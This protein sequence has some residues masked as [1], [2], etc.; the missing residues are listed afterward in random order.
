MTRILIPTDG[1]DCSQKTLVWAIE[2]LNPQKT[3]IDLYHVIKTL[4]DIPM[5]PFDIEEANKVL[6]D[7]KSH[8]QA[9]G[10]T[11]ER[12]EYSTGDPGER[13]CAAAEEWGVD[14]VLVGSHGRQGLSKLLL[15]SVSSRVLE[16]CTKPV[17]VYRNVER[18]PAIPHAPTMI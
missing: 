4:P 18:K 10:F 5:E 14:Q 6:D 1:S 8:L 12:S 2:T 15:G 13:I 7:A 3:V 9:H 17:F 11:V 16:H